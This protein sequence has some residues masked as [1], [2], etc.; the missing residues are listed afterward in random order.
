MLDLLLLYR[1][2]D[3]TNIIDIEFSSLTSSL[4]KLIWIYLDLKTRNSY[5]HYDDTVLISGSTEVLQSCYEAYVIE[6]I[7]AFIASRGQG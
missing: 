2:T 1:T 5:S 3:A 4:A 6:N 7:F